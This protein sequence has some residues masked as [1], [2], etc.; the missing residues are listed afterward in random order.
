MDTPCIEW[1]WTLDASGYGRIG[2]SS[3]AHRVFYEHNVG[4]IPE[5][6]VIDHLCRNRK[7]VNP[8]HMEPV[9]AEENS[10]RGFSL[11][12]THARQ[13]ECVNGH[14]FTE[15]N[16][17][18]GTSAN[19]KPRRTCKICDRAAVARYRQR[20]KAERAGNA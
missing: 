12:V 1:P 20:Q 18:H 17:R 8:A 15:E 7:C 4:P 19:G 14:P 2:R 10:A 16:T 11:P 9:T 5:G 3:L 6:Y 13:T